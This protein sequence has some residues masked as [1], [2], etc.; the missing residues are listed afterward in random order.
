MD[1]AVPGGVNCAIS[2]SLMLLSLTSIALLNLLNPIT[3][4]KVA[5]IKRIAKVKLDAAMSVTP[6]LALLALHKLRIL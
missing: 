2:A 4:K 3:N 1:G 5:G 6:V